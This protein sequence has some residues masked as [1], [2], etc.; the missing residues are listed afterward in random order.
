MKHIKEQEVTMTLSY[1]SRMRYLERGYDFPLSYIV[2]KVPVTIKVS[3]LQPKSNATVTRICQSCGAEHRMIYQKA[4][5]S[6]KCHRCICDTSEFRKNVA[7]ATQKARKLKGDKVSARRMYLLEVGDIPE[8][9]QIHHINMNDQD[10]RLENFIA[11]EM[12]QHQRSHGSF[13]RLCEALMAEGL[14]Y[15]DLESLSYQFTEKFQQS[16]RTSA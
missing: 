15:F 11:L 14:V 12:A 9:Y 6:P 7:I 10:N 5:A 8:G 2:A 4:K 16:R 3:D 1:A 13:N